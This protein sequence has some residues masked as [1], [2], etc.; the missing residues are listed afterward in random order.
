ML[1]NIQATPES[2]TTY[3][4]LFPTKQQRVKTVDD[5][6]LERAQKQASAKLRL[7]Q[8]FGDRF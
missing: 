1:F 8:T 2:R 4:K 7:Q 5:I 3:D 6:A